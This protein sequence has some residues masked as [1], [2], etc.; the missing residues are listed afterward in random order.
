MSEVVEVT[1]TVVRRT[2]RAVLVDDGTAEHWLPL[3]Q[4][5]VAMR[6]HETVPIATVTLPEWLARKC[7]MV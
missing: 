3:S 7:G 6:E 4:V 1:C 5:D 2:N